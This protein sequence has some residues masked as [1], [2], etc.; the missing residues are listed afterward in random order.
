MAA[1]WI[2]HL[3]E[4][5]EPV[6]HPAESKLM[7]PPASARP[8]PLQTE[9]GPVGQWAMRRINRISPIFHMQGYSEAR[10][11][12]LIRGARHIAVP[13]QPSLHD[14]AKYSDLHQRWLKLST[15]V[16]KA[17][18]VKSYAEWDNSVI[19]Y[20]L[21]LPHGYWVNY[22]LSDLQ[23][24]AIGM[25]EYKKRI[26]YRFSES[27]PH[28]LVAGATGSGKSVA[29]ENIIFALTRS[30]TPPELGLIII[31][32]HDAL[33]SRADGNDAG[34]FENLDHLL[35][36][37]AKTPAEIAG[38]FQYAYNELARR[39]QNN[40]RGRDV[41]RIAI[42]ADELSDTHVLGR[43]DGHQNEQNLLIANTLGAEGRK[44][45]V[46]LVMGTQKPEVVD[47]ELFDHLNYR[48]VGKVSNNN[49][50]TRILGKPGFRLADLNGHGDF[51]IS[52]D[53]VKRFQFA[54][55]MRADFDHLPRGEIMPAK[56]EPSCEVG[57]I[58]AERPSAPAVEAPPLQLTIVNG[59][60]R[61]A[62]AKIKP[63]D[64]EKL[65]F[66]IFYG[67]DNITETEARTI[68]CLQ[69]KRSLHERHRDESRA[70]V[71][72]LS[73]LQ[74]TNVPLELVPHSNQGIKANQ[75]T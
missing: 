43:K 60:R 23:G 36:P 40:I 32:P 9:L 35:L 27:H 74:L 51:F 24:R 14:I 34:S 6:T 26:E 8:Y 3:G 66:Y 5:I 7:E 22:R 71:A 63:T 65:A 37:I 20:L 72:K 50:G 13:I 49:L 17:A 61:H 69:L 21:Q 19:Y 58:P 59:K 18:G 4:V 57:R 47:N 12:K 54:L 10:I 29:L 62:G 38:A 39:K 64:P 52:A 1:N 48:F 2:S 53:Q 55:P 73:E 70:I 15:N 31:D 56:F 67:P 44:F 42:V 16:G 41:Q 25:T 75:V 46:N 30:Y 28:A 45:K 68:E 11:G 33:G